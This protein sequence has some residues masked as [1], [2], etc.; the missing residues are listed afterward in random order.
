MK[1]NPYQLNFSNYSSSATLSDL[2]PE[3]RLRRQA[4]VVLCHVTE[5]HML[6]PAMTNEVD[7]DSLFLLN[8]TGVFIWEHLDGRRRVRDLG[9]A[10]AKAFAIETETAT[11]DAA[12]FLSNLLE[13]NL[14]E[15][16][17]AHWY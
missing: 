4:G 11:A 8:D 3:V 15:L 13:H 5:K 12:K 6:V 7:L 1:T 14:V 2:S 16:A 9:I 10:M 17:E